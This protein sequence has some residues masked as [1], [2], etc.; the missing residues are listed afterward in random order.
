VARDFKKAVTWFRLAAGQNHASAQN[1]LGMMYRSGKGVPESRVIA[2]ALFLLSAA[3]D[4]SPENKA[5]GNRD[6]LAGTLSEK[7]VDT[8]TA[9]MREMSKLGNFEKALDRYVGNPVV[10]NGP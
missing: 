5:P 2:Y 6:A 9:L 8:A 7:E 3:T 10:K 4:F 1:S